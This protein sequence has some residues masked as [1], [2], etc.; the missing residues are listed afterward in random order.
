MPRRA[1]IDP[2]DFPH[3]LSRILLVDVEGEDEDGVGR[4]RYRVVG[5]TEVDLRGRDPTGL[6]VRDGFFGPS[7]DAVLACY[8][9]V[10]RQGVVLY[11]PTPYR[12]KDGKWSDDHTL[13]LPLSQDDHTVNQILVYAERRTEPEA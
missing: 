1:D 2:I 3:H 7:L 5:T 12:A 9:T 10:R 11:D 4:F 6:L 13:F 8:E